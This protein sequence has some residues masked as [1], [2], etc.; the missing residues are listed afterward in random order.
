MLDNQN[1][2]SAQHN[3]LPQLPSQQQPEWK[4]VPLAHF[5]DP[6]FW[7]NRNQ[8]KQ[9]MALNERSYF[10]LINKL[11]PLGLNRSL[12]SQH[13]D[14]VKLFY[15]MDLQRALEKAS[16]LTQKRGRPTKTLS[17]PLPQSPQSQPVE[18]PSQSAQSAVPSAKK[19]PASDML[20][21]QA[22]IA[23]LQAQQQSLKQQHQ[24]LESAINR[25]DSTIANLTLGR[26]PI[27]Q[28]QITSLAQQQA[29]QAEHLHSQL[30]NSGLVELITQLSNFN[31]ISSLLQQL[32]SQLKSL[33]SRL[34]ILSSKTKS[35]KAKAKAA[36]KTAKP[37]PKTK[38]IKPRS[39]ATT[40]KEAS[41]K[42][43]QATSK[44]SS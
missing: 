29:A 22:Q 20:S 40:K 14:R 12:P 23:S 17:L 44:S 39:K 41:I 18:V 25:I 31:Q 28:D 11:S 26:L 21:L 37:T 36:K 32:S 1:S 43:K 15:R 27:I 7:L 24:A 13:D 4:D 42:E 3:Y 6:S 34:A 30:P 10:R 2:D 38:P 9:S 5:S 8:I 19:Q 33:P 16:S 35:T